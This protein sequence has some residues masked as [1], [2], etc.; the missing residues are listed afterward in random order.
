MG[1]AIAIGED[2]LGKDGNN[3][4]ALGQIYDLTV[5]CEVGDLSGVEPVFEGLQSSRR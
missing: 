3:I 5:Q 1:Q 2:R 4:N